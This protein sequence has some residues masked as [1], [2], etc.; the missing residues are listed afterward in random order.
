MRGN[1]GRN[2]GPIC[3]RLPF[4]LRQAFRDDNVGLH[5]L[6]GHRLAANE[7]AAQQDPWKSAPQRVTLASQE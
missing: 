7:R 2:E 5:P 4:L 1:L 3:P 6:L